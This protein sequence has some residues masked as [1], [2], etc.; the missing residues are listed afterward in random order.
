[1]SNKCSKNSK[2]NKFNEILHLER[3]KVK[4]GFEMSANFA[5]IA[6]VTRI[7]HAMWKD[8]TTNMAKKKQEQQI[9][10]NKQL[11]NTT[12][13]PRVSSDTAAVIIIHSICATSSIFAWSIST[14]VDVCR[15]ER[16]MLIF[17]ILSEPTSTKEALRWTRARAERRSHIPQNSLFYFFIYTLHTANVYGEW[18]FYFKNND[19]LFWSSGLYSFLIVSVWLV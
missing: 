11:T 18:V 12:I 17:A 10:E 19:S 6:K 16:T 7:F 3:E 1:M 14:I 5:K 13:L 9:P 8:W 4:K 2:N 15:F